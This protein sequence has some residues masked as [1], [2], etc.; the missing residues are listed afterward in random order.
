MK[1]SWVACLFWLIVASGLLY[2]AVNPSSGVIYTGP[3]AVLGMALLG[4]GLCME[5]RKQS[6]N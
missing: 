6:A 5:A 3:G 4:L 2:V 1:K